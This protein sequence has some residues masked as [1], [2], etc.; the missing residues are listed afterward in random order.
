MILAQTL[1]TIN[2][3]RLCGSVATL[4]FIAFLQQF[5]IKTLQNQQC[6][7]LHNKE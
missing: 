1:L 7:R 2:T 6:E 4:C 3:L 5:N